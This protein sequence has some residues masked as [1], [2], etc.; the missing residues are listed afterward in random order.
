VHI[1]P[2]TEAASRRTIVPHE[3]VDMATF[4]ATK[5]GTRNVPVRIG[6]DLALLRRVTKA[7]FEVAQSDPDVL[8]R[9]FIQ[10]HTHGFDDYRTLVEAAPWPDLVQGSGIPESDIRSLAELYLSSHR[11]VIAWCLGLTQHEHGVDTVREI[12]NLLLLSGNIGRE[13]AGPSPVRGHSNVQCNRTCGIDHRPS[14]AFLDRL[15]AACGVDPSREHGL[16][17]VAAIDAMHRGDVKVFVALGGNFALAAPDLAYAYE[18]LRGCDLTVR[19]STKINRSHL[20]HG[21]RALIL[22]CLGRTERDHQTAG[23]QGVSVEDSMSMV[24]L[25]FGMKEPVSPHLR[26]ECAIISGLAQANLPNSNTPWREYVEDYDRI[27][28]TMAQA[29]DGFENFNERV[30]RLH[31]FRLEQPA[32]DRIFH[33]PTGRA[34]FWSGPCPTTLSR[35]RADSC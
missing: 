24:H 28:D 15:A 27:R 18:A 33:T 5:I 14:P 6:G 35:A 29:L 26:S 32:R 12:V 30:R 8:D 16:D 13:G 19:V 10:Q 2:L 22:P 1:N 34:E 3:F 31:G 17:T 4:H 7:V 11:V 20:V 9:A 23:A 25:S 21:R